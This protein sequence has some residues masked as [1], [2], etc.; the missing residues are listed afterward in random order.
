M[1]TADRKVLSIE[2]SWEGGFSLLIKDTR[3]FL[4]VEVGFR[5]GGL[6]G[7]DA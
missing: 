5:F 3:D 4:S 1:S 6:I 7:R 2:L